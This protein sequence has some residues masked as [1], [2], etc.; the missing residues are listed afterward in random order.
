M[1]IA[2]NTRFLL[3][4]KMEG[5]GWFTYETVKRIVEQHPEHHFFFFFD[6]SFDPKFVF[7]SHI[8]P[9]VLNPPA[10][11]PVLFKIW[12]DYSVTRALKKHQIDLFFSPDGYL[13]LK[14]DV[15]QIGVIH[16]LNFEHFPQDLP[17]APLRYLKKYFPLFAQKAVHLL[18]VSHF[19][20]QD[21][22]S[23]YHIALE[24]ITVAHNGASPLFKPMVE[25]EKQSIRARFTKEKPYFIFVGALHPRK[26]IDRL[27]LAFDSFKQKTQS[28]TQ[29]LI[30]GAQLWKNKP[31]QE[32]LTQL[33]HQN[34]IHFSGHV[35]LKTL[36]QLMAG[37]KALAF[38][39]YFEGFGIPLV[40][41]MQAGTPILAGNK[42]A[43]PEVVG[44]AGILVD[45][46]SVEAISE[47]LTQLDQDK[48][49]REALIAKGFERA[50]H[51]SW[52][53][54]A[55]IIWNEIEKVIKAK[56]SV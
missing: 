23:T 38:V 47:G 2:I 28:D 31:F 56:L 18:T 24:K 48:N 7:A 44:D 29:L 5:F 26:N 15:P 33:K 39:S 41:A 3:K 42:T 1:R 54:T 34:A 8:T 32:K 55:H 9:I 45:P 6:R 27:L 52:D 13:S 11:H 16:D 25:T 20:K 22:V 46:Y 19:S 4:D 51:Y 37:A 17:K 36:T 43:L 21:I 12:F 10:R 53:N 50:Q 40:E 35:D 14:T 49:L 30:V